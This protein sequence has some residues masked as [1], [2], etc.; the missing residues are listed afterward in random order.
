MIGEIDIAGIFAPTLLIWT[1]M[2][3]LISLPLR[4][5]MLRL[6]L[7]RFVWHR[8]LFDLCLLVILLGAIT[9]LSATLLHPI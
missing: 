6:G 5:A 3:L 2:A 1:A 8:G 7:Y 4:W 9:A